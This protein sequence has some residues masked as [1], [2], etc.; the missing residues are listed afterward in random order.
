MIGM[1]PG[2]DWVRSD[3]HLVPTELSRLLQDASCQ[4]TLVGSAAFA[5]Y[6]DAVA[7]GV[8][9]AFGVDLMGF[10]NQPGPVG[11]PR[12]PYSAKPCGS[13]VGAMGSEVDTRGLAHIG[14]LPQFYHGMRSV[15]QDVPAVERLGSSADAFLTMWTAAEAARVDAPPTHPAATAVPAAGGSVGGGAASARA[16]ADGSVRLPLYRAIEASLPYDDGN[17]RPQL[18]TN[19]GL[20]VGWK[21]YAMQR[22]RRIVNH[23]RVVCNRR[24]E[25]SERVCLDLAAARRSA[26][27]GDR[28]ASSRAWGLQWD[29]E[30]PGGAA[31]FIAEYL[32]PVEP[33]RSAA[34]IS[35]AIGTAAD[36]TSAF[37]LEHAGDDEQCL[38]DY[39]FTEAA[40]PGIP[41]GDRDYVVERLTSCGKGGLCNVKIEA[42][43]PLP[44]GG[45]HGAWCYCQL[46]E[47]IEGHDATVLLPQDLDVLRVC[48]APIPR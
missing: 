24:W 10:I 12:L 15:A 18:P 11:M 2:D 39:T 42:A 7:P 46:L 21:S 5:S 20:L 40:A 19:V 14:L 33:S 38:Y 1:R 36:L 32:R 47:Y 43:Q 45:G 8:S 22:S 31:E 25:R 27:D 16:I 13:L 34:R 41:T 35:S 44:D 6:F 30:F 4:G 3:N 17:A 37:L 28:R 29:R 48:R 26:S 23:E 9:L